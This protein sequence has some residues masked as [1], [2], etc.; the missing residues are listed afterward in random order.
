MDADFKLAAVA[1]P[2]VV[3]VVRI[4][5]AGTVTL[6]LL[7]AEAEVT[8]VLQA[9][10]AG[11]HTHTHLCTEAEAAVE[12]CQVLVVQAAEVAAVLVVLAQAMVALLITQVQ[13]VV[14]NKEV[15][16][17]AA[18]GEHRVQILEHSA[19]VLNTTTM[20][21]QAVKLLT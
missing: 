17:V 11:L 21:K 5:E 13:F 20:L 6:F 4:L 9:V 2:V 10:L 3:V 14:V 7:A 1:A 8:Q 19:V 15:L 16:V 18:V 12:Y